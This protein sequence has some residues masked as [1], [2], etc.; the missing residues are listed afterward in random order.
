M[1]SQINKIINEKTK[2]EEESE[3]KQTNLNIKVET[4]TMKT[5]CERTILIF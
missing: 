5:F 2:K 1:K 4:F 3:Y